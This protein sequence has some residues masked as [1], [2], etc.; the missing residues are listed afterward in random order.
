VPGRRHSCKLDEDSLV[1][2]FFSAGFSVLIGI[3]PGEIQASGFNQA[4]FTRQASGVTAS[5][6]AL[7]TLANQ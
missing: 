2:S 5:V 4:Y 7:I 3:P 1:W 6:K